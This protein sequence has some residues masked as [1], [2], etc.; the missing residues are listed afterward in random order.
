MDSRKPAIT[1]RRVLAFV[2]IILLVFV[3]ALIAM[4]ASM[5][6]FKSFLDSQKLLEAAISFFGII[7]GGFIA[8]LIL[9]VVHERIQTYSWR[10]DQALKDVDSIY[11]PLY[12]DVTRVAK[13]AEFLDRPHYPS[14][15]TSWERI[16]NSYLGTKLRL[17]EERLY[18]NLQGIFNEYS[19]YTDR[20]VNT[21]EMVAA[22]A[23]KI[24]EKQ[25]DEKIDKGNYTLNE[26]IP[27][28]KPGEPVMTVK[29]KILAEMPKRLN[30]GYEIF[31]GLLKGK[32]VREWSA[33]RSEDEEEYLKNVVAYVNEDGATYSKYMKFGAKEIETI[34]DEL[35]DEV[36]ADAEINESVVWFEDY[37]RRAQ[38]L[39]R[40]LEDRI[41]RPQLP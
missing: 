32:S 28:G 6:R 39:K 17:M 1:L 20:R 31:T 34:L 29:D 25:L 9:T 35:H 40:T 21:L 30:W 41:L 18:E 37:N 11:E 33:L 19:E 8:G 14:Q 24:I 23:K 15:V 5:F 16:K 2:A 38:Q 36:Q 12:W 3:L 7:T 22:I 13:I 4:P 26:T 10:R 27:T